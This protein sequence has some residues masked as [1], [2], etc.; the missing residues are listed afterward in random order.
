MLPTPSPIHHLGLYREKISL[1]PVEYYNN[2]PT[3]NG[4]PSS[5]NAP[6][7]IAFIL[8]PIIATGG[9]AEAAIQTLREW[10]VKKIV[11]CSVLGTKDGVDRAASEW[12]E[13]VEVYVGGMDEKTNEKG[14]IIP[15]CVVL[16]NIALYIFGEEV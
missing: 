4:V 16:F 9:T 3:A 7:D 15:G 10:G 14:M 1:Q 11:F 13:G 2:L 8:D 5:N 6:A 12:P